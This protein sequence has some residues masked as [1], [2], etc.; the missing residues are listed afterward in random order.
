MLEKGG[1]AMT[2]KRLPIGVDNFETIRTQDY[3]YVD[4]TGFIIELLHHWG[5]VNLFTR[6]RQFGKSLNVSM[7]KAFLEIGCKKALFD[8]LKIA[9]EQALCAQYMGQYPVISIDL[10]DVRGSTYEAAK[11]SLKSVIG[12]EARRFSFL[13][14][15]EQLSNAEKTS[16]IALTSATDDGNFS[17]ADTALIYS[18]S[19][20]SILLDKHYGRNVIVLIDAYDAPLEQALRMGYDTQMK[21]LLDSLLTCGLQANSHVHFSVITGIFPDF[22]ESRLNLNEYS[23]TDWDFAE[24]FG[25]S[26]EEVTALLTYYGLSE[27]RDAVK[28]WCGGYHFGSADVYCPEAVLRFCEQPLANLNAWLASCSFYTQN[29]EIVGHFLQM[30]SMQTKL[31]LEQLIAGKTIV[32]KIPPAPTYNPQDRY[33]ENRWGVLATAGVLPPIKQVDWRRY[34]LKIPNQGIRQL[35]AEQMLTIPHGIVATP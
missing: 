21:S 10:K 18:L 8:G 6:P 28:E 4:K 2:R 13:A 31:E 1:A 3:Y 34:E 29:R 9:Q 17:M 19:E 11:H 12:T 16:Y 15:S 35:I 5:A 7:L 22:Q 32:K 23:I 30:A 24:Y 14:E 25:F 33:A 20:L 27:K 26:D